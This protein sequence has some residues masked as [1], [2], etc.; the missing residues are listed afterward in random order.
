MHGDQ[1]CTVMHSLCTP[2]HQKPACPA[3]NMCPRALSANM[4]TSVVILQVAVLATRKHGRLCDYIVSDCSL[5][6]FAWCPTFAGKPF[7]GFP[8]D[9]WALGVCL[10][11][12]VYG[13][14]P[15]RGST[16]FQVGCMRLAP[17]L[18]TDHTCMWARSQHDAL[19]T[20]LNK[21]V[22]IPTCGPPR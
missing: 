16:A 9:M 13:A 6:R 22:H 15:F 3:P 11:M 10:W 12:F 7:N 18:P 20:A 1:N 17:V 5:P 19:G 2:G 8:G 14:P 21:H 4:S